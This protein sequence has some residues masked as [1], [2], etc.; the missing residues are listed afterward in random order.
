MLRLGMGVSDAMIGLSTNYT[1]LATCAAAGENLVSALPVENGRV[2]MPTVNAAEQLGP[3][4]TWE[5]R[6]AFE[7][8]LLGYVSYVNGEMETYE[9]CQSR[10]RQ[11][12]DSFKASALP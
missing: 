10:I 6:R 1:P 3:Y 7:W 12:K 2:Y 4:T 9:Y 11:L 5:Q 8:G